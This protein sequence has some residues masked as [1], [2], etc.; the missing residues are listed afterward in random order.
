MY[1]YIYIFIV[2]LIDRYELGQLMAGIGVKMNEKRIDD[3]MKTYDV[4]GGIN[5]LLFVVLLVV[6]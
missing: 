2:G 3:V 4:S 6:P 5:L 1:L